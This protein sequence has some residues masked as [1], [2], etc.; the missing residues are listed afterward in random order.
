MLKRYLVTHENFLS[1]KSKQLEAAA[2]KLKVHIHWSKVHV[3][4]TNIRSESVE[5][6]LS[7][8]SMVSVSLETEHMLDQL[9]LHLAPSSDSTVRRHM[10]SGMECEK[11][12]LSL[13]Y[14]VIEES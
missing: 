12:I 8:A 11:S 14:L 1:I 5:R 3:C 2:E 6:N 4:A 7:P 10:Q 9:D 13:Y